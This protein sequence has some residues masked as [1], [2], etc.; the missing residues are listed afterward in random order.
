MTLP[1]AF[2]LVVTLQKN[3]L[4][5]VFFSV[6]LMSF[7]CVQNRTV[8]ILVLNTLLNNVMRIKFSMSNS[9][10]CNFIFAD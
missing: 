8:Q 4:Q 9:L 5:V 6:I 3:G 10:K 2:L 7:D 1:E